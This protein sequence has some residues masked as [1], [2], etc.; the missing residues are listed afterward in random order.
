MTLAEAHAKAQALLGPHAFVETRGG[1]VQHVDHYRV[2]K[3]YTIDG[4][5]VHLVEG[6]GLSWEAALQDAE[7]RLRRR[8]AKE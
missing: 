7:D 8:Y 6:Y 1:P 3:K 2:M 4:R 5:E